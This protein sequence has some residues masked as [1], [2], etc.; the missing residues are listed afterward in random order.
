MENKH[1]SVADLCFEIDKRLIKLSMVFIGP[2]NN[3][4]I[5]LVL[6]IKNDLFASS[7][8]ENDMYLLVLIIYNDL[9]I[10]VFKMIN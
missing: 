8:L 2:E 4:L 5:L 10:M 3:Q 1:S 7:G 6:K 9:P